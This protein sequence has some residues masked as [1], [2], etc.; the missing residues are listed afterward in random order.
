MPF[1]AEQYIF[2]NIHAYTL[3]IPFLPDLS[4]DFGDLYYLIER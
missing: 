3:K 1:C 4:F 2:F